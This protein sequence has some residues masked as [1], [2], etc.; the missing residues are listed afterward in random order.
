[1][2]YHEPCNSIRVYLPGSM[3]DASRRDCIVGLMSQLAPVYAIYASHADRSLPG[4][5]YWLRFSPFP[6]EFQE[7]ETKLAGLIESTLGFSRLS[8][9]VLFTPVPDLV[10]RI[11]NHGPGEARLIDCLFTQHRW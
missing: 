11:A 4:G 8:N 7:L 9:E 2:P 1:M 5:D 3:P 10:P 6:T